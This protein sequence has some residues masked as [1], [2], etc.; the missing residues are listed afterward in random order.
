MSRPAAVA[1]RCQANFSPTERN[2]PATNAYV[3]AYAAGVPWKRRRLRGEEGS[4]LTLDSVKLRPKFSHRSHF[5]RTVTVRG[6]GIDCDVTQPNR[7]VRHQASGFGPSELRSGCPAS[8]VPITEKVTRPNHDAA[9]RQSGARASTSVAAVGARHGQAIISQSQRRLLRSAAFSVARAFAR[10]GRIW[11]PCLYCAWP[12]RLRARLAQ[13][14]QTVYTRCAWDGSGA[15]PCSD[16]DPRH[17]AAHARTITRTC[18]HRLLTQCFS[19]TLT[20]DQPSDCRRQ[21]SDAGGVLS[22]G[23]SYAW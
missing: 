14:R 8:R 2:P 19:L 17:G 11:Q 13:L 6:R 7:S 5:L 21:R 1:N 9:Q 15:S 16:A 23:Q 3:W 12:P 18:Q 20:S 22:H 10:A 4:K